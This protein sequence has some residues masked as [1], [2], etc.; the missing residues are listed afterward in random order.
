M[1]RAGWGHPIV[2]TPCFCLHSRL[3]V[4]KGLRDFRRPY[5]KWLPALT[6]GKGQ[7]AYCVCRSVSTRHLRYIPQQS[8]N[9]QAVH[10][11]VA[12]RQETG[13]CLLFS[14]STSLKWHHIKLYRQPLVLSRGCAL[15]R[16]RQAAAL[17]GSSGKDPI[18]SFAD[19]QMS[20][21]C[22]ESRHRGSHRERAAAQKREWLWLQY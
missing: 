14:R 8:R 18:H 11:S 19:L 6:L 1:P 20:E 2:P 15:N 7:Q 3:L 17:S 9:K 12:K 10:I 21:D 5:L 16:S 13:S 4:C 22:P